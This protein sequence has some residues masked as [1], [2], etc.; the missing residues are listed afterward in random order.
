MDL[1]E[2]DI[3]CASLASAIQVKS[4]NLLAYIR[5]CALG[6]NPCVTA[7]CT[8]AVMNR[9]QIVNNISCHDSSLVECPSAVQE[10]N[11]G[12]EMSVL[13][14]FFEGWRE[15]WSSLHSGDPDVIQTHGLASA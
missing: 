8:A 15:P 9:F 1:Q 4:Y 12:R 13:G 6:I 3:Q 7:T 2:P 11:S 5:A 14:C 10:V